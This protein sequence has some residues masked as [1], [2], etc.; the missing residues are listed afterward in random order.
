MY[1]Y[2]TVVREEKKIV[3]ECKGYKTTI[4][5]EK[6][7]KYKFLLRLKLYGRSISG[8]I[9]LDEEGRFDVVALA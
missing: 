7:Y 8:T 4:I 9:Y 1:K 6:D 5:K 2:Q 3:M